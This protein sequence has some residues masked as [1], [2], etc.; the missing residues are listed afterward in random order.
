M[1]S[2]SGIVDG[3]GPGIAALPGVAEVAGV[4]AGEVVGPVVVV[5]GEVEV[6]HAAVAVAERLS[7]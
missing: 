7:A 1:V 2:T 4:E 3:R 6:E 5:V